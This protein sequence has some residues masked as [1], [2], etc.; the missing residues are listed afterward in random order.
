MNTWTG[1]TAINNQIDRMLPLC[2]QLQIEYQDFEY[3]QASPAYQLAVVCHPMTA[4]FI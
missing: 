3:T 2:Q 4:N 1:I